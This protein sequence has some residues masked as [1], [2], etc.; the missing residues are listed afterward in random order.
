METL[1]LDILNM[2]SALEADIEVPNCDEDDDIGFFK[3][4]T[5]AEM[6][7]VEKW[8]DEQGVPSDEELGSWG[9]V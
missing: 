7:R 8:L 5:E 9:E 1:D 4:A 6:N 3:N 2:I